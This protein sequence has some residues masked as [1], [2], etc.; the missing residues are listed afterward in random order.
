MHNICCIL[1]YTQ[2]LSDFFF[3]LDMVIFEKVK[4]LHYCLHKTFFF[5]FESHKTAAIIT[6]PQPGY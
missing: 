6:A 1:A 2:F 4:P 5:Y 3:W